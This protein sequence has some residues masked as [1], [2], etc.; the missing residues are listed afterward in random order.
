VFEYVVVHELCHL[1]ERNHGP[2]FWQ[3]VESRLPD[4]AERRA[5]LKEHG[6]ALG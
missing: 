5:W 6:V 1:V 4:F 2:D 3:L